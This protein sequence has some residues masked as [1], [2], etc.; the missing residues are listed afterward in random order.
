MFNNGGESANAQVELAKSIM[1][2]SFQSAFNVM[3]GSVPART[4]VP[5][6]HFDT[7]G[8]K[9]MEDLVEANEKGTLLGSMAQRHAASASV[10]FAV[11]EVVTDHFN[12]KYDSANAVEKLVLA[13]KDTQ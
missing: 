3:K 5:N 6:D 7:C 11:H 4:D 13:V 8:K 12:G 9:G 10:T 1:A 2:P